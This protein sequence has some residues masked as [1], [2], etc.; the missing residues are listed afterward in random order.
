MRKFLQCVTRRLPYCETS[1]VLSGVQ[2]DSIDRAKITVP[3]SD[4]REKKKFTIVTTLFREEAIVRQLLKNQADPV[5]VLTF[6]SIAIKYAYGGS[7]E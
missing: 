4:T 3:G 2:I 6:K 5:I 1:S 7:P